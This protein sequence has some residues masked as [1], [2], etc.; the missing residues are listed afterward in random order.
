M[1]KFGKIMATCALFVVLT[2]ITACGNKNDSTPQQSQQSQ[3]QTNPSAA[4]SKPTAQNP[5]ESIATELDEQVIKSKVTSAN[6]H[7]LKVVETVN[8]YITDCMIAGG[9]KWEA[10]TIDI[11]VTDGEWTISG[12]DVGAYKP[13]IMHEELLDVIK[14]DFIEYKPTFTKVFLN[15]DGKAYAA[16]YSPDGKL[17]DS[18][19]PDEAA[20]KNEKWKWDGKTA[21]V[22]PKGNILGTYPHLF[23]DEG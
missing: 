9:K 13:D 19:Y 8:A 11:S 1:N 23:L 16:I 17:D 12:Y 10:G 21:G 14:T 18:E 6:V 5:V 3:G 15:D 20:F 4:Q 22:T 2:S 7:A